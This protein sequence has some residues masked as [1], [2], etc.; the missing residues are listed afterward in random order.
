ML[1]IELLS[2]KEKND[3]ITCKTRLQVFYVGWLA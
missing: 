3:S 2:F 1:T